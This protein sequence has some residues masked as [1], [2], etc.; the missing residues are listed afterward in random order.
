MESRAN[1]LLVG[2]FVLISVAAVFAFVIWLARVQLHEDFNVYRIYFEGSVQGL[3]IGGDVQY[4]GIRIGAITDLAINKLAD[5]PAF[6]RKATEMLA[7]DLGATYITR[8]P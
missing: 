4:R 3:G 6:E 1:H 5:A 8:E 7:S 2:S